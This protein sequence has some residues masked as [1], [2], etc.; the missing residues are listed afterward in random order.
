MSDLQTLGLPL[1]SEREDSRQALAEVL[2]TLGFPENYATELERL[3][4][5]RGRVWRWA[6]D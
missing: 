6:S 3:S 1:S 4:Y 2:R 5:E